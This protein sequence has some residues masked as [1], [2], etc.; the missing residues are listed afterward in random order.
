MNFRKAGT[1]M[2]PVCLKLIN[3]IGDADRFIHSSILTQFY[4][5]LESEIMAQLDLYYPI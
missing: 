2:V 4:F 1:N 5:E 3:L